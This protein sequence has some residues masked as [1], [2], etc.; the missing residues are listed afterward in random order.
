MYIYGFTDILKVPRFSLLA[1][2]IKFRTAYSV[3]KCSLKRTE[4][5]SPEKKKIHIKNLSASEYKSR[6]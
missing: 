5:D 3:T 1:F 4:L 2:V 6:V